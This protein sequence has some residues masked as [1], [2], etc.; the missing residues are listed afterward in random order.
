M[1]T[2][3]LSELKD[4]VGGYMKYV[5]DGEEVVIHDHDVPVARILPIRQDPYWANETELVRA[6]ILKMPEREMDWDEFFSTPGADIPEEVL[7]AAVIE[8]RGDR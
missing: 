5:L 1:K 3:E 2:V 4:Q 6:G 8:G 7:I